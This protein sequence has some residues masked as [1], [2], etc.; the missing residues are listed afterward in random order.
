MA[1][2]IGLF[3][4]GLGTLLL[5]AAS[6]ALS[7]TFFSSIAP[8][9]IPWFVYAAMGLTEG[10]LLCWAAWFKWG[11]HDDLDKGI[12]LIVIFLCFVATIVIDTTELA[13]IF[14]ANFTG[15]NMQ[16][17]AFYTI[18]IMFVAHMLAFIASMLVPYFR[19]YPFFKRHE[20]VQVDY[21]TAVSELQEKAQEVRAALPLGRNRGRPKK[22]GEIIEEGENIQGANIE[23]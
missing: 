21:R 19:Q 12:A 7:Y 13:R 15:F 3:F 5:F 4:K 6:V 2:Y 9:H 22:I 18:V 1:H 16:A 14:G 17:L 8:P 10:G 23:K 20:T 11:R